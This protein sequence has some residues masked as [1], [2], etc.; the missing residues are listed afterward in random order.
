MV[1]CSFSAFAG[2]SKQDP[3]VAKI[4]AEYELGTP[5]QIGELNLKQPYECYMFQAWNNAYE[6]VLE[7]WTF[8]DWGG[9]LLTTIDYGPKW[10][11]DVLSVVGDQTTG[12]SAKLP[13]R[14]DL[15]FRTV[16]GQLIIEQSTKTKTESEEEKSISVPKAT[17]QNFRVCQIPVTPSANSVP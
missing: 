11:P 14:N 16:N 10:S 3:T 13:N 9:I 12:I 8:K 2:L 17:S 7:K 1:M 5:T 6:I 4:R 15:N